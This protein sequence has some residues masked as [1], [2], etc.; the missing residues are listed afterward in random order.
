M[1]LSELC[2]KTNIKCPDHL[3]DVE[4][5]GITS[6][7]KKVTEGTLFV[8]LSGQK[9]DGHRYIDEAFINGA[10]AV[11]VEN[12]RYMC[13][14]SLAV[15]STREALARLMDVFCGEPSKKLTLIAVTGTNGKTSVSVMIKHIFET[16][17]IPCEVIGTLNCSSFS[18]KSDDTLASFTTPDPEELYPMLRRIS[19]A[20][21]RYVV[22]ETSSHALKLHKLAPLKF[23]AAIFTNLTED[24]LDFHSDM[25]DYFRSKL[26]VFDQTRLG[27][28]NIDDAYGKRAISL[29]PCSVMTCSQNGSADFEA[30]NKTTLAD[31][32]TEYELR[33]KD[34][35]SKIRCSVPGSFS[36]TN[37]LQAASCA[38]ALGFS[39]DDVKRAFDT[40]EG[41]RGRFERVGLPDDCGIRVYI[42]YAHTPDALEKVLDTANELKGEGRV[43]VLF[44]CGGEREREKR[45]LMG[46]IATKRADLCIITSDNPRGESPNRIIKDILKGIDDSENYA[47]IPKRALAIEY[48]M[49]TASPGDIV[50]LCGKGHE[51]YEIKRDGRV[52][53]DERALVG[54]AYEKILK[55]RI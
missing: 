22:M 16:K 51:D 24:H 4:I 43:T 49:R 34:M 3:R 5:K 1:K 36:V 35:R 13:S 37:S 11:I 29:L 52:P 42:D 18:P 21:V 50:L 12:E 41:V 38:L 28:I 8:C 47:V 39:E 46:N 33:Y 19:D 14:G 6:N 27:I 54:E 44:G 23:E 2:R 45:S 20:G 10:A 55:R 48:A 53:F 15:K 17:K 26:S 31:G 30:V 9:H 7:S 40:F 32:S 25:E